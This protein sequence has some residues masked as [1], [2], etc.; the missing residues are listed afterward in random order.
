MTI[1]PTRGKIFTDGF[2]SKENSKRVIRALRPFVT[3]E[4]FNKFLQVLDRRTK[5]V[6]PVFENLM[7]PLNV[8]AAIRT[9][10]GLGVQNIYSI[11]RFNVS[12]FN[13]SV[14]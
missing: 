9:C 5:N 14:R 1:N 6:V 11:E 10:E 3:P 2:T 7:D 12:S 4:R 8:G 13:D